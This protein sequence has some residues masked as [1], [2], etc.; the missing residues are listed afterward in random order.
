L[1]V[2]DATT[3]KRISSPSLNILPENIPLCGDKTLYVMGFSYALCPMHDPDCDRVVSVVDI[4]TV[5]GVWGCARGDP[6]Y[7]IHLDLDGDLLIDVAD[8]V[9]VA[10]RNW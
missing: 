2:I 10:E 8:I 6:C 5:A 7:Q 4:Q 3:G 1:Y 9:A